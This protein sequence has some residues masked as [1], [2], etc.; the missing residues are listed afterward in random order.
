MQVVQLS[1]HEPALLAPAG[2][3]TYS[4][5]LSGVLEVRSSPH[6][7]SPHLT[8]LT[9]PHPTS[10]Q[11]TGYLQSYNIN[12]GN[13]ELINHQRFAHCIQYKVTSGLFKFQGTG[14]LL[15][16]FQGQSPGTRGTD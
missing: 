15:T 11:L 4:R 9:S 1:C 12:G 10:P 3:L 5:G 8:H 2:C 6:L 7:T 16:G 13:G 14:F